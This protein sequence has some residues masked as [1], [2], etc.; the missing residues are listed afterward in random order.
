M[1]RGYRWERR[2]VRVLTGLLREERRGGEIMGG[3]IS[4]AK[5]SEGEGET[6]VGTDHQSASFSWSC[7]EICLT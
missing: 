6:T 1:R 7:A 3:E 5:M 4:R 2:K